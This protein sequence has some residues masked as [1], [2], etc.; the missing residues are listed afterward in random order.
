MST[1]ASGLVEGSFPAVSHPAPASDAE[2]ERRMDNPPFGVHFT[3]HLVRAS[4]RDG[5]GWS[6]RRVEP[7]DDLRIH[8]AATALN[9]G[10]QIFEGL[11]A[12]RWDDGSV[13]LFRPDANAERFAA[14]AR[15][16]ALPEMSEA[17]FVGSL[18]ALV[19]VDRAWV[20]SAPDAS[21]YLRP[22][23][24]GSEPWLAVRPSRWAEYVLIAS[25]VGPYFPTGVKPVSIWV[26]Q[27]HHR[28]SLG[29]TGTA[30][31]GG[32]Y[33]AA[34]LPQLEADAHGCG[35]VL[36]LDARTDTFIEELG[37]MNI[38]IVMRDGSVVTPRLT[39]TILE[40]VTRE[41]VL[42]I[43]RD[44]G[45]VVVERD[46]ALEELRSGIE[47]GAVAEVFA[48]G[49]A[50]AIMPVGRLVSPAFDVAVSGGEPGAVAM[51]VRERLLGIQ[52]GRVEDSFGWM[53]V[54]G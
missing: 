51:A 6:G 10:Q 47:S 49:T 30:K 1:P 23:L 13:A 7:F 41:S 24:I 2:R 29:G 38:L 3:D 35:Q 43:L 19:A 53:R 20:S 22:L 18:E 4:W 39:G 32:N 8:P 26:S 37:A 40:G 12:Y 25:P 54:V 48:C 31:A 50:A 9:Y 11:K 46:V 34:M 16:M 45:R 15:R 42:A 27:G 21:L 28:A 17:D 36:F 14:S 5:E 44:E 52:Y 33:G